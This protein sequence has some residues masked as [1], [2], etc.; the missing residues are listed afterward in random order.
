LGGATEIERVASRVMILL[1]GQLLT[2]DAM[3]KTDNSRQFRLRVSGPE[4]AIL[5]DADFP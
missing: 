3:R 4:S 5:T 1:D 2:T